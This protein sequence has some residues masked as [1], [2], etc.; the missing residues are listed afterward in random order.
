MSETQPNTPAP[1][2][3]L[4]WRE[5]AKPWSVTAAF[6]AIAAAFWWL[7]PGRADE[8]ARLV[9][10]PV[11]DAATQN[12]G[13][14]TIVLAGGC[15]WGVQAVFQHTE[16]VLGARSG[17]AGG[18]ANTATYEQV[19][20]GRTGHAESVE[21]TFDPARISQGKILQIF[22]S[23]APDP[24]QRDR[25]GPDVG[26]QYRSAIFYK[27]DAQKRIAEAY[28]AQLDKAHVFKHPVATQV[29]RLEAFYE[30]E[31]YHQDYAT[32]HPTSPYIYYND[33]PKVENL[34]RLFADAYRD[35]PVLVLAAG[36][37]N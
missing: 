29:T 2:R 23:V 5:F 31:R 1:V 9:P 7:S 16:G 22:F 10:P 20:S 4:D 13:P 30:A 26:P 24:T 8:P 15:F 6:L 32:L 3:R 17:Y 35:N 37:T 21:V 11:Q 12:P 18:T 36:H 14:Q 33:R 25:Q 19:S 27:D 34:K 28:I